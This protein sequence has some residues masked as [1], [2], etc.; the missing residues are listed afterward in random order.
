MALHNVLRKSNWI[1]LANQHLFHTQRFVLFKRKLFL[2]ITDR[3]MF[4]R[5]MFHFDFEVSVNPN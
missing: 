1:D 2:E 5:Y 3:L 4:L